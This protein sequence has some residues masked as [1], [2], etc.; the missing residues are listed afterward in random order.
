MPTP[1]ELLSIEGSTQ[2]NVIL[3]DSILYLPALHSL[4]NVQCTQDLSGNTTYL[5]NSNFSTF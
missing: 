2:D 3:S 5:N 1:D 4:N